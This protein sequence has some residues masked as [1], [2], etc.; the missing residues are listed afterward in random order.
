MKKRLFMALFACLFSVVLSSC[1]RV[2]GY[3]VLLWNIPEVELKDGTVVPVYLKSNISGVYVIGIPDSKEKIEVPQ[4]K[5]SKP[6]SKSKARKLAEMYEAYN[7]KYAACTLDGLPIRAESVNTSEQVYRLRKS[8]I[9]KTLYEGSGE[10]PTNGVETLKGKWIKVLTSKGTQG[11]CFSANL[12]VFEMNPDGTYTLEDVGGDEMVRDDK[13]DDI[14]KAEWW[15]EYYIDMISKKQI[16]LDNFGKAFRFDSGI[17]SGKILISLPNFNVSAKYS[18]TTKISE[19]EYNFDNTKI[20]LTI[21]NPKAIVVKY[22]GKNG[23]PRSFNFVTLEKDQNVDDLV[24]NEKERRGKL[25]RSIASLGPDFRSGNYG[26]LTFSENSKFS[27]TNYSRLVPEVIPSNVAENGTVSMKYFL[28]KNLEKSW[29]GIA[30]FKFAGSKKEVNLF[31]KTEASGL[32][33]AVARV[34]KE[35]D[36]VTGLYEVTILPPANSTVMFFQK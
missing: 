3:S 33:L 16:D 13:I 9:V 21:R 23:R 26:N 27:W 18:G 34:K 15:P 7:G 12:N 1:S 20:E 22:T 29:D 4:W 36:E 17:E 31:F 25:F 5:L 30:T 6:E 2:I 32:R 14:L 11:W 10:A 24:K 8:E 19:R 28:P 35:L